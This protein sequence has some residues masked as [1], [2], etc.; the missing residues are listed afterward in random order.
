MAA[1]HPARIEA[2]E[3]P[4]VLRLQQQVW[5]WNSGLLGRPGKPAAISG[6]L[7]THIFQALLSPATLCDC[8]SGGRSGG[9]GSL[10][11]GTWIRCSGLKRAGYGFPANEA[12]PPRRRGD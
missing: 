10:Q 6:P 5:L 11:H 9:V 2:V 7:L 1:P 3:T 8:T 4:A 12:R